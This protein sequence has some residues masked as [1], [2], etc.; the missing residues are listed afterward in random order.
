[1][2]SVKILVISDQ[3]EQQ[4]QMVVYVCTYI[5][6]SSEPAVTTRTNI[7]HYLPSLIPLG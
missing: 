5:W 2:E 7:I 4:G 1:M 6:E 3:T